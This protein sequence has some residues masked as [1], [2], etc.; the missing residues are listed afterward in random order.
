MLWPENQK[1]IR[2]T[3][4]LHSVELT[5]FR[6]GSPGWVFRQNCTDLSV[7]ADV[8]YRWST[9]HRQRRPPLV[10]TF[11]IFDRAG[12][13]SIGAEDLQ[14]VMGKDGMGSNCNTEAF[15]EMVR[16]SDAD[17]DGRIGIQD[18]CRMLCPS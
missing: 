18:F 17:D 16:L 6:R 15:E 8:W 12:S 9:S 2:D 4:R 3:L 10:V 5:R 1:R 14:R 13:G 11:A 7:L